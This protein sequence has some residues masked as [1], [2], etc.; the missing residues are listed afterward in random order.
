[1]WAHIL[2]NCSHVLLVLNSSI[3]ILIYCSLSSKFREEV[4]WIIVL[5]LI[6][7]LTLKGRS[8]GEENVGKL[9][10]EQ[11][12]LEQQ[13]EQQHQGGAGLGWRLVTSYSR[14]QQ[15]QIVTYVT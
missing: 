1:M 13:Q 9:P 10:Q 11:Q 6:N 3:N 12:R 14:R 5:K 8:H 15:Q 2:T 4:E 7:D